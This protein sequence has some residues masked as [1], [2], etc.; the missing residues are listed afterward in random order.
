MMQDCPGLKTYDAVFYV[1]T[2]QKAGL[3]T[4]KEDRVADAVSALAGS[5]KG[6]ANLFDPESYN[7][8]TNSIQ[9]LAACFSNYTSKID[10]TLCEK[11]SQCK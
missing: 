1:H 2:V 8:D 11:Q 5:S 6:A 9:K 7:M 3:G 4:G 10:T